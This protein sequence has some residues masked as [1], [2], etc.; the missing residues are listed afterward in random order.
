M[1]NIEDGNLIL[2]TFD[3]IFSLLARAYWLES[4]IEPSMQWEAYRESENKEIRDIS[5]TKTWLSLCIFGRYP[6]TRNRHRF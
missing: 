4:Q 1:E 2:D 6:S 5:F 3:E